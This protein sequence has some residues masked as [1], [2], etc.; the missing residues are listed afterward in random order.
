MSW[1]GPRGIPCGFPTAEPDSARLQT[2][3][4]G[5][6]ARRASVRTDA[7]FGVGRNAV[8]AAA[9]SNAFADQRA[10]DLHWRRPR[11]GYTKRRSQ[12]RRLS[13]SEGWHPLRTRGARVRAR[14]RSARHLAQ[15]RWLL[16]GPHDAVRVRRQRAPWRKRRATRDLCQ[17][18]HRTHDLPRLLRRQPKRL[19]GAAYTPRRLAFPRCA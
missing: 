9:L 3:G 2:S 1:A 14:D 16:P 13:P 4:R 7:V 12:A 10:T 17:H 5:R 18:R 6:C 15:V 8:S 11:S 19:Y